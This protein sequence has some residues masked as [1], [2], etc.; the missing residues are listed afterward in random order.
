M[1]MSPRMGI[2]WGW[3]CQKAA[4]KTEAGVEHRIGGSYDHAAGLVMAMGWFWT[5]SWR[6]PCG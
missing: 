4:H 5:W 6:C 1:G 2:C 3:G